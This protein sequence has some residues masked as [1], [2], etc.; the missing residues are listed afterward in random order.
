MK[1]SRFISKEVFDGLDTANCEFASNKRFNVLFCDEGKILIQNA[2][3]SS[4]FVHVQLP[5]KLV[6]DMD[7]TGPDGKVKVFRFI[8][9]DRQRHMFWVQVGWK[10]Y[11]VY[12]DP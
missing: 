4:E 3:D 7:Y 10:I 2:R 5:Q 9:P 6:K 8:L 1:H 12:E 11:M